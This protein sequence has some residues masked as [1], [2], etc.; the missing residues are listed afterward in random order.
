MQDHKFEDATEELTKATDLDRNDGWSRYYLAL[1][2]YHAAQGS[3]QEFHGLG[4]MMQD[5]RAVLDWYPDFAQA[6]AML[7][8]ARI[9][10]GGTN[11]ALESIRAA[12]R[13]SPRNDSYSLILAKVYMA[14]KHWDDATAVLNQLKSSKDPQIVKAAKKNLDDLPTLKKYGILPQESANELPPDGKAATPATAETETDKEDT[15]TKAQPVV[16]K[17]PDKRPV[18]FVK[19]TLVKVDCTKPWAAV[20]TVSNGKR[21]L[22]L[23][24]ENYKAILLIGADEF[25]CTWRNRNVSVN[26]KAGG[27]AD[28]D[29]VSVEI[30]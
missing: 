18:L 28:G 12:I 25:S 30:N 10:G 7:A 19:G 14:G 6:Y 11:S 13:L 24:T 5:L 20:M 8:I 4:N 27:T 3:G 2:K 29:L 21:A 23:R 15:E 16:E 9:E 17:E 1:V 26:Y 22:K